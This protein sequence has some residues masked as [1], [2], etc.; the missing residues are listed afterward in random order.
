MQSSACVNRTFLHVSIEYL[1]TNK[2]VAV[3]NV[4]NQKYYYQLYSYEW[5]VTEQCLFMR[6]I[7]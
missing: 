3:K 5:I 4:C 6:R 7:L 1:S 2:K